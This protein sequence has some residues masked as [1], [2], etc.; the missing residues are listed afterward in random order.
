MGNLFNKSNIDITDK[1]MNRYVSVNNE[2]IQKILNNY[3]IIYVN[4]L[5]EHV[6]NSK[7]NKDEYFKKSPV[8]KQIINDIISYHLNDKDKEIYMKTDFIC[9]EKHKVC[10]CNTF[11][12]NLRKIYDKQNY[13]ENEKYISWCGIKR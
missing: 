11:A 10:V 2:D 6:I 8:K 9:N 12:D 13:K 5:N 1:Y 4:N 7:M 3:K